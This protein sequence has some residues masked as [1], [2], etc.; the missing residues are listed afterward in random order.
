LNLQ[1]DVNKDGF[2]SL[3]EMIENEHAFY[4]TVFQDE[5]DFED[6]DYYHDEFR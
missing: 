4:G 6:F 1:A 2:L 3:K 5:E